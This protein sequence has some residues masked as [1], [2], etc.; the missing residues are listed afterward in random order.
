MKKRTQRTPARQVQYAKTQLTVERSLELRATAPEP[1]AFRLGRLCALQLC[2]KVLAMSLGSH[3]SRTPVPELRAQIAAVQDF[4]QARMS[5]KAATWIS[6][7][8]NT[9]EAHLGAVNTDKSF[10]PFLLVIKQ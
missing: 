6:K 10:K 2:G 3:D 5:R 1:A 8:I 9:T 4:A 7:V